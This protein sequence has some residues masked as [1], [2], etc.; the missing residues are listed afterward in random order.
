MIAAN[1]GLELRELRELR[2][3]LANSR[4]DLVAEPR[5]PDVN[6][7]GGSRQLR[8]RV[9]PGPPSAMAGGGDSEK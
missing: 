5:M 1:I 3:A 9:T 2:S 6:Y 7:V 4:G 8:R